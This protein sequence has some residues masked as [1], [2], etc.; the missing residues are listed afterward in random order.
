[1][2]LDGLHGDRDRA[3]SFGSVAERY[4]RYRPGYPDRLI[5]DVLVLRPRRAVDVGCGTGKVAVQLMQRGV[6]VL[7]VEPDT[8]MAD[9]ARGHGVQVEQA[10]FE[11]WAPAGRTFDL[12]TAGHSWHWVD[13]A[14]GLRKAAAVLELGGT[15]ALFWN[16]HVVE[17][18]LLEALEH[19]YGVHAPGLAIVGR[20]PRGLP[21]IDPFE[22]S[23][24]FCSVQTRT[25]RWR[26]VLDADQ[27]AGLL[28]TFSD[29]IALG[30][31]RL[32]ALQQ[33]VRAVIADS[34][35][36]VRSQCGTYLWLA[37]RGGKPSN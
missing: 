4:D 1:M 3:E 34:G 17:R 26:R 32:T 20:D 10:T 15:I 27:W 18:P 22:A 8:R 2:P 11:K 19:V 36:F 37:C 14:V 30:H 23:P 6:R 21:D 9:L 12:L 35:G 25:Y 33:A 29:H 13:P 7:G 16:Y 24:D 31:A 28:G 5:D